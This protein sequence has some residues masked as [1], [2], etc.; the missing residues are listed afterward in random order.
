MNFETLVFTDIYV[1]QYLWA[2]RVI[3]GSKHFIG[4]TISFCF[5]FYLKKCTLTRIKFWKI[6]DDK[7]E[8]LLNGLSSTYKNAQNET[9]GI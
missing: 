8:Y 1:C 7:P 9:K 5:I 2:I 3:Q 6:T 4:S